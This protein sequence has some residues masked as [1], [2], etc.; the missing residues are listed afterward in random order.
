M[1]GTSQRVQKW[2]DAFSP[3]QASSPE[4]SIPGGLSGQPAPISAQLH[5]ATK[6]RR[7]GEGEKTG[8]AVRGS[9]RLSSYPETGARCSP[10]S[11]AHA[12]SYIQTHAHAHA[13]MLALMH[14]NAHKYIHA[15]RHM[16]TYAHTHIHLSPSSKAV[17]SYGSESELVSQTGA[18]SQPQY[19]L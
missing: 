8:M 9:D 5:S 17:C 16:Q 19:N 3:L 7:R 13:S 18:F 12:C 14:S 4:N 15:Y 11:Y 2:R 10:I 6:R 1:L